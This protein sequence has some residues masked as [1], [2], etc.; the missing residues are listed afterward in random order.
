MDCWLPEFDQCCTQNRKAVRHCKGRESI[1][2]VKICHP[3]WWFHVKASWQSSEDWTFV[4]WG[5]GYKN[6]KPLIGTG[7]LVPTGPQTIGS[8]LFLVNNV[9]I[10]WYSNVINHPWLGMV[11]IPPI[12]GDWGMVYHCYTH[13]TKEKFPVFSSGM[14]LGFGRWAKPQGRRPQN[15]GLGTPAQETTRRVLQ[16][17]RYYTFDDI[18]FISLCLYI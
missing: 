15:S 17:W 5:Y 3:K 18:F 16:V 4:L 10:A 11:N 13:I 8:P 6:H 2:W 9:G 1:F 14:T 7:L 12:Y